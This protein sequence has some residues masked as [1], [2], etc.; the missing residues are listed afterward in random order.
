MAWFIERLL[1]HSEQ[2]H[3]EGF[4]SAM[5][6]Y[7]LTLES[8]LT[9]L[10]KRERLSAEELEL[11]EDLKQNKTIT[12]MSK[13]KGLSRVTTSTKIDSL[14]EKLS[15][16]LGGIYTDEGYLQ[17]MKNTYDLYDGQVEALRKKII[18]RYKRFYLR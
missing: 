15:M 6:E 10:E 17:Y 14:T 9:E 12:Q 4:N 13:E 11:I 1:T 3:L 5:L 2:I 16:H 8:K 18:S 7:L